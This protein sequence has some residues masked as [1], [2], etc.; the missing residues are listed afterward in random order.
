MPAVP[1]FLIYC[2]G[3][4]QAQQVHLGDARGWVV[5]PGAGA[6]AGVVLVGHCYVPCQKVDSCWELREARI[7]FFRL[8]G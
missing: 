8:K 1:G 4:E 6:G 5:G 2:V 7:S 3:G